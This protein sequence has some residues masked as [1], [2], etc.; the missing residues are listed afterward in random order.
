MPLLDF[1]DQT[2]LVNFGVI[3]NNGTEEEE[4]VDQ[5]QKKQK[6]VDAFSNITNTLQNY[7]LLK[8]FK[9]RLSLIFCCKAFNNRLS[10]I[11]FFKAFKNRLSLTT[12]F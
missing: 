4:D 10:L 6:L 5:K 1:N 7:D 9:N 2:L 11:M 3:A 12:C 8:A